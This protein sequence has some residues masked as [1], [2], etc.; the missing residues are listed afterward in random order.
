MR[1]FALGLTLV[2]LLPA[3]LRAQEGSK[4]RKS[5]LVRV[6]T[7]T[8]YSKAE[9]ASMVRRNC[10]TFVP[11]N[12]DRQDLRELGATQ[13][14]FQQI[15]QCVR[16]GNRPDAPAPPPPR[17]VE[18]VVIDRSSSASSGSVAY[19]SVELRRGASPVRG[20]RLVLH[21]ATG[22]PG[23]ARTNPTAVTDASGRAT[24]AV[25]AGT[26]TGSYKLN[27]AA[28][29]GSALA[30][31]GAVTLRTLPA[32]N[33]LA[34][35]SPDVIP[36]G[37]GPAERTITVTLTDP[38]G[39]P[40]TDQ[41]IQLRPS[42]T[43]T[44]LA[45]QT[46]QT[47]DSGTVMFSI[48][49]P[50]LRSG[51]SLVVAS[52]DRILGVVAVSATAEV[53]S[54]LVEAARLSA[55]GDP[56]A[57]AVYTG[58]LAVEPGNVDALLGR[59]Y[60]RSRAGEYDEARADFQAAQRDAGAKV[61]ALTGLGY[62]EARRGDYAAAAERFRAALAARPNDDA[63]ATGLAFA[64]LWQSDA[65]QAARRSEVLNTAL[66]P[67]YPDAAAEELR[68]GVQQ[69]ANRKLPAAERT[70]STAV[71]SAP[72]WPDAY[73]NRALAYEANGKTD[74][75]RADFERYLK[76][77]PAAADRAQV[78]EH[79][80]ALGRSP[81]GALLRGLIVPGFGQFYTGR[82]VFGGALLAAV[83]G[84]AVWAF[85]EKRTIEV[86]TYPNPFG[87]TDTLRVPVRERPNFTAGLAA[88]GGLWLLG[89]L[90][91]SLHAGHARGGIPLPLPLPGGEARSGGGERSARSGR[92][93]RSN[94]SGSTYQAMLR[95]TLS[96]R[97]SSQGGG[98]GAGPRF[99]AAISIPFR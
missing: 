71:D 76:L 92:S 35:I 93:A 77:R 23:G 5:D 56:G 83:A 51:D 4:L 66:T 58:I 61:A 13:A 15:D 6:L 78:A 39:N 99:G 52:G 22:I 45:P 98:G 36:L 48:S 72:S 74:Q 28:A 46:R 32:G 59:G 12:R 2:I 17:P 30:G 69:L 38:F 20:E 40:V 91:A 21:G 68:A 50:A 82:P 25:P 26:R 41:D 10:L 80:S 37:S 16:K 8:T 44:G 34:R 85:Q 49:V 57:E 88:A 47:S 84:G 9:I 1:F 3:A 87:G 96:F 63:A 81:N 65:H 97:P 42:T 24:F 64:E 73:Y 54:Q 43:R 11:T 14:V 29:D 89:A 31:S 95:P 60:V 75:A 27:I 62:N 53:A 70:L 55:A 94:G 19:I 7:G 79:M 86:R 67:A 90:E 33:T 18:L